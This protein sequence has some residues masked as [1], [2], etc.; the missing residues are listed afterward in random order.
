MG[1]TIQMRVFDDKLSIWNEGLLP[2]GLSLEDLKSDHNSRPRNPIIAN[3][4]FFAGYIDTWGR[5]TL[6]II[7]A[8]KEAGL[9]EPETKEMNGGV[10]VTIF[11]PQLQENSERIRKE[12]GMIS[13]RFLTE[14]GTLASRVKVDSKINKEILMNNFGLFSEYLRTKFGVSSDE[15][16]SKFGEI[17]LLTLTLIIIDKTVTAKTIAEIIGTSQ[18]TIEN[19]LTKLRKNEI[20]KRIGS[21]K[22]GYYEICKQE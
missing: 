11:N 5:G 16:R 12:F 6:K 1:A 3:A 22:S 14:F 9:P 18:R 19:H 13:E 2:F 7:N 20:V 15:I 4:C 21:D 8:C 10:E 17:S